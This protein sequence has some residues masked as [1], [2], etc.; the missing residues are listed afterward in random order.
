LGAD[1]LLTTARGRAGLTL[2]C[3]SAVVLDQ[4]GTTHTEPLGDAWASFEA[5]MTAPAAFRVEHWNARRRQCP[6]R[7]NRFA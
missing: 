4:L 7:V 1:Y 3:R 2:P 5:N 6:R